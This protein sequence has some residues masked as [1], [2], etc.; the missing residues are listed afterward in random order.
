MENGELQD[1]II[2]MEQFI[3]NHKGQKL[4]LSHISNLRKILRLSH[5]T[6]ITELSLDELIAK[7]DLKEITMSQ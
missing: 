5:E 4:N 2:A 7:Y 6:E 3:E 1:M